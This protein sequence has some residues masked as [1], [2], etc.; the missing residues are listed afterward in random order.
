MSQFSMYTTI[1][2]MNMLLTIANCVRQEKQLISVKMKIE[3]AG[4]QRYSI[5]VYK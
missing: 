1:G 5:L 4:Q 3:L 2:Q